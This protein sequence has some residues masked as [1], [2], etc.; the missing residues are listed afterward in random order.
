MADNQLDPSSA[1]SNVTSVLEELDL[2]II[3]KANGNPP[4]SGGDDAGDFNEDLEI[5][6]ISD[7]E[8]ENLDQRKRNSDESDV[9]PNGHTNKQPVDKTVETEE[10]LEPAPLSHTPAVETGGENQNTAVG[11][12]SAPKKKKKKSKSKSKRGLVA[13]TGFEEYYVDAPVTPAEFEEEKGL[14]DE[15]RAFTERIEIAIQRYVAK[16]NLDSARKDLFDKYLAYGGIEAG[17]KMFGGLATK[18]MPNL[19]A[20][21]IA[22]QRARHFV[23]ADKNDDEK[24]VVDFEACA[25]AFLSSRLPVVY[26]LTSLRQIK[27]HTTVIFNF[28][29]YLL[30]HDVAPEYR[31]QI[32]AARTICTLAE[33]E[34]WQI[35]QAQAML[36]GDFNTAC[37]EIFGGIFKGLYATGEEDWAQGVEMTKR[38]MSPE[39]ARKT[40]KVGLAANAGRDIF[41]RY[42]TQSEAKTIGI[43]SITDVA[44]EVI[45]LTPATPQVQ[46]IYVHDLAKGLKPLGIL[47][48]KTWYNPYSEDEDLTEE[49]EAALAAATTEREVK[50]YTFWVED[51]VLDKCFLGMKFETTVTELSFG[52]SY[53]DALFG[54]YCSFYRV[55]PNEMM[56]GWREPGPKLPMRKKNIM[57]GGAEAVD[58]GRWEEGIEGEDGGR[59]GEEKADGEQLDDEDDADSTSKPTGEDEKPEGGEDAELTSKAFDEADKYAEEGDSSLRTQ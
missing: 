41:E 38:G 31:S 7:D 46:N 40:F 56:Y 39:M 53:F 50:E 21:Q 6:G 47:K 49:E 34:L 44:L 28:L 5:V 18:D 25:A 30:H 52:V 4:N 29:N 11:I 58:D 15:S 8:E 16:R 35:V 54:V 19:N 13:P 57:S 33:K 14:Y 22:A 17:P 43:T 2:N 51:Y 24:F 20:A 10:D 42:K 3:N 12:G 36:P 37:S 32:Y 27:S 9:Q 23:G 26:D 59:E 45:A 55:L 1:E 48:A